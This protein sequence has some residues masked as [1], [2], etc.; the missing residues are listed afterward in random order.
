MD[1]NLNKHKP[2][3]A[4]P[5]RDSHGNHMGIYAIPLMGFVLQ[6][7][8]CA[9]IPTMGIKYFFLCTTADFETL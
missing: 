4:F 7:H 2:K 6:T 9:A 1:L 8:F 3:S 5:S